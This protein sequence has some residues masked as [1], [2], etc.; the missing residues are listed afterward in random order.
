M[1]QVGTEKKRAIRTRAAAKVEDFCQV[2][3]FNDD[4]NSMEHVV[5]ALVQ[6]FNHT[7]QLAAKIMVEAHRK[8]RAIAEVEAESQA[9][10]HKQQLE[11]LGLTAAVEKL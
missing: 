7:T 9:V 5:G 3:L 1:P 11:S 10:L 6:V 4:V 2:I 8:G